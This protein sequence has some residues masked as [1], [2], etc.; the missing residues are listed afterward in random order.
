MLRAMV[1]ADTH[2][3]GPFRGHWFDKLR[4][5]ERNYLLILIIIKTIRD[6]LL[7][8]EFF[9]ICVC[10]AQ[11]HITD[12]TNAWRKLVL[13]IYICQ[14][15]SV[16]KQSKDQSNVPDAPFIYNQSNAS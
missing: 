6:F 8:Q 3:L 9:A 14:K 2:L 1:L 10:P 11:Y 12:F 15:R 5:F 4:R 13:H 16:S 7:V